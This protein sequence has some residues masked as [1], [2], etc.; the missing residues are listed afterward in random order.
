M[1]EYAKF[2]TEFA[3]DVSELQ[4]P[5]QKAVKEIKQ[6]GPSIDELMRFV[7]FGIIELYA[8][9]CKKVEEEHGF[10]RS[11][12]IHL[13]VGVKEASKTFKLKEARR[14]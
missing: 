3:E 6:F 5:I 14:R 12:A 1:E 11:E 9:G 7:F 13:I 4:E 8:D 2:I 10:T